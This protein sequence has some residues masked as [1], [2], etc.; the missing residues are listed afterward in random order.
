LR[1]AKTALE[2][3][4][5]AAARL[6][7]TEPGAFTAQFDARISAISDLVAKKAGRIAQGRVNRRIPKKGAV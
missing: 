6:K 2:A 4:A 3:V 1:A 7:E 5:E